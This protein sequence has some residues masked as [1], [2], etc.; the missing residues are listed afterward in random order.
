MP[1]SANDKKAL[2][3]F[4]QIHDL[5]RQAAQA[6]G[7]PLT[8]YYAIAGKNV[9]L[10]FAGPALVD[11]IT[12]A[13]SHLAVAPSDLPGLTIYLWDS[14]STNIR[15]RPP[16][17]E[18]DAFS[19]HGEISEYN[20]GTIYTLFQQG[21]DTLNL[22]DTDRN[23]GIFW[24]RDAKTIPYYTVGA[25]LRSMFHWWMNKHG[26]Q[27]LHAASVGTAHG[28]A[29]IVGKGGSGKST[30]AVACLDSDMIYIGDD[31]VLTAPEPAPY[32]FSL[33]N[34]AKLDGDHARRFAGLETIIANK[35][36]LN[37]EKA[38]AFIH[39]FY[40]R[41]IRA[42]LPLNAIIVPRVIKGKKTEYFRISKAEAIAALAPSTLF[43]LPRDREHSFQMMTSLVKQLPCYR[44]DLGGDIS[45]IP[46]AVGAV[47]FDAGKQMSI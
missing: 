38:I 4:N 37:T 22:L 2:Q 33:Y 24:R 9:C 27:L 29:L 16:P 21:E 45:G 12:P 41:R 30:T 34:T 14:D 25:P 31:Y 32:V 39:Q 36:R 3:F 11:Y 13:L 18:R 19:Y 40:P 20:T 42:F 1:E 10:S 35:N 44:L 17:W 26:R 46:A 23:I 28:A 8:Y 7:G 15:M 6:A 47:L 43:Q 5:Y